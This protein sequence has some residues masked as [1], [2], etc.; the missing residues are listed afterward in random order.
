MGRTGACWRVW[1]HGVP[2]AAAPDQDC[3][4]VPSPSSCLPIKD[5]QKV[6]GQRLC[7]RGKSRPPSQPLLPNWQ[8]AQVGGNHLSG[9]DQAR[10]AH[11]A[12][13]APSGCV[14]C[15]ASELFPA[16]GIRHIPLMAGVVPRA[17]HLPQHPSA[18]V[19]GLRRAQSRGRRNKQR[20]VRVFANDLSVLTPPTTA[21]PEVSLRTSSTATG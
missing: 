21:V 5:L 6:V 17:A 19:L 7:C 3:A 16:S 2:Q 12:T 18:Y 20:T 11:S 8:R 4:Q 10:G 13:R 15:K 14:R 9:G 1:C